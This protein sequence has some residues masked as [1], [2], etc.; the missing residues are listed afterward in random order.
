M[1]F[2]ISK[3]K[4]WMS[5]YKKIWNEVKSQLFEKLATEQIKGNNVRGK[6]KTWKKI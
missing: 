5:R 6:L 3:E 4:E 1:S 2:N